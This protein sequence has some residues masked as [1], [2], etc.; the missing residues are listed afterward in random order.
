MSFL[1][2]Q[3]QNETELSNSLIQESFNHAYTAGK[4]IAEVESLVGSDNLQE[5]FQ[6]N[7]KDIET[8]QLMQCLRLFK[9]ETI[10]IQAYRQEKE[11]QT[12]P[13]V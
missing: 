13:E 1:I 10:K 8:A 9:G 6:E 3:I 11:V 12:E 7:L 5:W 2:E 4:F